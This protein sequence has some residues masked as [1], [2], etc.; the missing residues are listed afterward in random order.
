MCLM[1]VKSTTAGFTGK[2]NPVLGHKTGR[3]SGS[4]HSRINEEKNWS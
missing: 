4:G 3:K 1:E 2:V